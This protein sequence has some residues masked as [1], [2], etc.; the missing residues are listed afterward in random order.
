MTNNKLFNNM[1]KLNA[2]GPEPKNTVKSVVQGTDTTIQT[3]HEKKSPKAI[4]FPT[5]LK[6]TNRQRNSLRAICMQGHARNQK[7]AI[8]FLLKY[9]KKNLNE[10]ERTTFDSFVN[11]MNSADSERYKSEH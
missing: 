1:N 2:N 7:D 10:E 9:Y 4:E 8:D 11:A 5:N 6:I 3:K